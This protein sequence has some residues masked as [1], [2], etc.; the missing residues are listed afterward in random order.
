MWLQTLCKPH[1]G[2]GIISWSST[3]FSK[4][5]MHIMKKLNIIVY[6]ENLSQNFLTSG[7][8]FIWGNKLFSFHF[9]KMFYCW[10]GTGMK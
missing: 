1:K 7:W 10:F 8:A 9:L 6:D 3:E 4:L 5:N 2:K